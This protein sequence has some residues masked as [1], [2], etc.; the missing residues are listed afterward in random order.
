MPLN[1]AQSVLHV[2]CVCATRFA[3][4]QRTCRVSGEKS[5]CTA[6][7]TQML[8][9]RSQTQPPAAQA[10]VITEQGP[11]DL[12]LHRTWRKASSTQYM[13]N[14]VVKHRTCRQTSSGALPRLP[15]WCHHW[16]RVHSEGCRR[17]G[18]SGTLR[19]VATWVA[20]SGWRIAPALRD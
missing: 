4:A 17:P 14:L 8:P 1:Q 13:K 15:S 9:V 6:P 20:W 16:C 11:T 18:R 7:L 19:R 3:C 10:Q 5:T 12:H 2:S